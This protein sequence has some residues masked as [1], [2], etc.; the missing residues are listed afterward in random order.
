M[1]KKTDNHNLPAKLDL[2]RYY[3]DKYHK[4]QP[5]QVLDCCQGS[6]V[7]WSN[8]KKE[9]ELASYWGLDLKPKAGRLKLDSVRVLAQPGWPQ[10]VIDI[11]AY[12]SPWKHWAAMLPHVTKPITVFLTLG[13]VKFNGVGSV[14]KF[15]LGS[16]GLK[17]HDLKFP[18]SF[19]TRLMELFPS[20]CLAR[21]CEYGIKIVEAS[22]VVS[23]ARQNARYFGVRL[24]PG[25]SND[26]GATAATATPTSRPKRG[27][28]NG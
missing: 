17:F 9:Y 18:V 24:E 6:G 5:P 3:L 21:S 1:A 20:Y 2:R 15:S 10:D 16:M 27:K 23:D 14:C 25:G 22:E 28:R 8:L 7:I 13:M 19:G 11:D 26:V 4:G 12:G